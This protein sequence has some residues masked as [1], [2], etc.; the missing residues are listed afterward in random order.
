M[1]IFLILSVCFTCCAT[2]I[3]W[4]MIDQKDFPS[5]DG[6]RVATVFEMS[7]NCTTGYFPQLTVRRTKEKI[8]TSGNAL[9]GGPSDTIT[10]KWT[11]RTNLLVKYTSA[12]RLPKTTPPHQSTFTNIAGVMIEINKQ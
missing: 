6:Q 7:C 1:R 2:E 3:D 10:V 12:I 4:E 8:G 11:S 9:Q 5:P